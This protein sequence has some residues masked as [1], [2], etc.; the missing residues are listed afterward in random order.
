MA[1]TRCSRAR[2]HT[3]GSH[4]YVDGKIPTAFPDGIPPIPGGALG[5]PTSIEAAKINN[6]LRTNPQSS[7]AQLIDFPVVEGTA[8]RSDHAQGGLDALLAMLRAKTASDLLDAVARGGSR[9]LRP[10]RRRFVP[11]T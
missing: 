4:L 11:S 7:L 3:V 10:K 5:T 2:I 1:R 6:L 9:T 8:P